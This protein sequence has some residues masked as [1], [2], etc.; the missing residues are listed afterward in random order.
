MEQ[1][2]GHFYSVRVSRVVRAQLRDELG[3]VAADFVVAHVVLPVLDVVP[4]EHL[5]LA[6]ALLILPLQEVDLLEELL[7]VEFEG[8]AARSAS[9][10]FFRS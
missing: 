4:P 5:D 10:H 2:V 3:H 9:R 7:L 1:L 6:D 8:A